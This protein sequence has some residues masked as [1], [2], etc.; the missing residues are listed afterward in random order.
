MRLTGLNGRE[1][2]TAAFEG[3]KPDR[4]PWA[5]IVF[6]DTLSLYPARIRKMGPIEFT[7]MIG[8][9]VLWRTNACRARNDALKVTQREDADRVHVNYRTKI[10]SLSEIRRRTGSG[11]QRI[12][13]YPVETSSEVKIL[14]YILDHQAAEPDHERIVRADEEVGDSGLVMVFQTASPVQSLVHVWMGL[15]RFCS[16]L[17]RHRSDLE[18][19]MALMHEKNREIYEVMA[20]SPA[21]IQCIVENTDIRLVSPDTYE[22]YSLG[23][24]KDYVDIMHRH[25]KTAMVHMCGK[26]DRLLPLIRRTGLDG[27]DC[28]TPS[29]T[30]DVDFRHAYEVLGDDLIVHGILDPSKWMSPDRS[31]EQIRAS[32]DEI[33]DGVLGRPFILCTAADGIPGIPVDRFKAIGRIV[34]GHAP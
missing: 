25:G 6:A 11:A 27:I 24:V 20:H 7:K 1:R 23:H 10:G 31:L 14:E 34:Q 5:P 16:E 8:G 4:M 9:D 18:N 28:L 13:K 15:T 17:L 12:Q 21:Q 26:I 2:L 19:L 33:A 29:P 3:K 30:G 32:I 22:R